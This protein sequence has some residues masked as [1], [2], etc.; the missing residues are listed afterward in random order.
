M[1]ISEY[2]PYFE[3]QKIENLCIQT[4]SSPLKITKDTAGVH[5]YKQLELVLYNQLV[6][7][8]V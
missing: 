4:Y 3:I 2:K 1:K 7:D 6:E 8:D 5:W